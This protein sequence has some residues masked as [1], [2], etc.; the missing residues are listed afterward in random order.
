M[1][2]GNLFTE[3]KTANPSVGQHTLTTPVYD[4]VAEVQQ[5]NVVISQAATRQLDALRRL[6]PN[7]VASFGSNA[8]A[9]LA[10][11]SEEVTKK[12]TLADS[13]FSDG[14]IQILKL[15]SSVDINQLGQ[16][17]ETGLVGFM[18]NIKNKISGHKVE[19][20]A[21][22]NSTSTEIKKIGGTLMEG[23]RR[24]QNESKW[25]E[26][27]YEQN[28]EYLRELEVNAEAL[29]YFIE[30]QTG[31]L[32]QMQASGADPMKI[33][34]QT[35]YVTRLERQHDKT[36]RLIQVAKLTAPEIRLMQ[37][38]NYNNSED[39][40]DLIETTI[41]AWEKKISLAII[42]VRQKKDT[43]LSNT[44]KDKSNEFFKAAADMVH[45]NSIAAAQAR[46]K[47]SLELETIEH[48]QK[49]MID[50][51]QQVKQI[52]EQGRQKRKDTAVRLGQMNDELMNE[53]R[54]W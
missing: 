18:T 21:N 27:C 48:M 22:F 1:N 20:M 36:I 46:N 30:E 38:T 24:M 54:T 41:P 3:T 37:Q 50:A 8:G 12:V 6:N 11:L 13:G 9:G 32:Q 35:S 53:M 33:S 23:V 47:S 2:F 34:D 14:V 51:V 26:K 4:S 10:K 16:K 49:Q 40:K 17:K 45:D 42:S 7:D 52:D 29:S 25:L 15:T 28:L 39:F 5:T 19:F 44:V 43:E 31:V